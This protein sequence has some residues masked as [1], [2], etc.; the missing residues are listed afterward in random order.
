[1]RRTSGWRY[2]ICV[3]WHKHME[4]DMILFNILGLIGVQPNDG[5]AKTQE[6]VEDF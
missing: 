1:M 5:L 2:G 6:T 3:C 4:L